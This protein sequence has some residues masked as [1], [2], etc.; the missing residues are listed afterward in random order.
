MAKTPPG[1]TKDI[2]GATC[3]LCTFYA[4]LT[5]THQKVLVM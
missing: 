3:P 4:N 1:A 5:F 2:L